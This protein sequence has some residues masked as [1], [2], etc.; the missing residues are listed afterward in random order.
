MSL[1]LKSVKLAENQKQKLTAKKLASTRR[2]AQKMKDIRIA[3]TKEIKDKARKEIGKLSKRELWLI[4][5]ALYWAEG[6]KEKEYNPGSRMVFS[7]SD[8]YMIKLFL[9]WLINII[10]VPREKI[11]FSIYIHESH[12]DNLERTVIHWSKYT[13]YPKQ[14]FSKIYFK[15]NKINTKRKNIRENYFGLLRI[16]VI[17]SSTLN[18]K[19]QGWT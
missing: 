16:S 1:W 18:R 10:K 12:K 11:Y 5:V 3:L 13:D 6:S 8:P 9:K 15:R 2:G 17:E 19:I 14:E 4:G 7:N